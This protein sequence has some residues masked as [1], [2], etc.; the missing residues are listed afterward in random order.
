MALVPL[1]HSRADQGTP[2]YPGAR[3][4]ILVR[5]FGKVMAQGLIP[6]GVF[7]G[8]G[9]REVLTQSLILV[10]VWDLPF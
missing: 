6:V 4:S 7:G 2:L 5:L 3:Q 8:G 1:Q 10:G 9:G